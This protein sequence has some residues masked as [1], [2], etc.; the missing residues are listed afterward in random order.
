MGEMADW[1][2]C[3]LPSDDG[4]HPDDPV[5]VCYDCHSQLEF[6]TIQY[7]AGDCDVECLAC[8]SVNTGEE[9]VSWG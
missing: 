1:V 5:W 6:K 4:P 7:P 3:D 8:G 9:V 2:N